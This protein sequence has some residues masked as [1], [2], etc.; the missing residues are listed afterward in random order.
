MASKQAWHTRG[1]SH[2]QRPV[3]TYSSSHL[4]QGNRPPS[5]GPSTS[6]SD[7]SAHFSPSLL[8]LQPCWPCPSQQASSWMGLCSILPSAHNMLLS[9]HHMAYSPPKN[10]LRHPVWSYIKAPPSAPQHFQS[11]FPCSMFSLSIEKTYDLLAIIYLISLLG[12]LLTVW[13]RGPAI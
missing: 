8:L 12:L 10:L 9:W 5:P 4:T 1:Q 13:K 6:L 11:S 3:H 7:L 2:T